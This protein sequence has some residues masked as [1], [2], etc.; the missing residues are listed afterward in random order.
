LAAN[1]QS[2]PDV[3]KRVSTLLADAQ[4]DFVMSSAYSTAWVARLRVDGAALFPDAVD[5]LLRNQWPDGSWGGRVPS[6]HDRT[7]CTLA[8][9]VALAQC[10]LPSAEKAIAAGCEYLRLHGGDW[11]GGEAKT[12]GFDLI[13]PVLAGEG[14]ASGLPLPPAAFAGLSEIRD[15]KLSMF[16]GDLILN[17]PTTLLYSLEAVLPVLGDAAGLGR[18]QLAD[19]SMAGSPSATAGH[20]S[21]TGDQASVDYLR[22]VRNPD[23]GFPEFHPLD[24]F[25]QAW[26]LHNLQRA[27]LL[28]AEHAE[29]GLKWLHD[30]LRAGETVGFSTSF[31]LPDP[32][33]TA[34]C[35]TVLLGAGHDVTEWLG[36]LLEFEG[37]SSF[38]TYPYER[39]ASVTPNARVLQALNNR[40][41]LFG[42]QVTK[43]VDY[44][45]GQRRDGAWW[46]DKWHLSPYY[47]TANTIFGLSG[48]EE[49]LAWA[50]TGRWL[51]D[52]QH[53]N[54]SWGLAGGNPEET[55]YAVLALDALPADVGVPARVWRTAEAYLREH[56]DD[57][58]FPELWIGKGLY[59]PV[60]VV[61]SA[62]LAGYVRAAQLTA[63]SGRR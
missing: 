4:S 51:V 46:R 41:D 20:W 37:E 1:Q 43:V 57:P 19:G 48:A 25:S 12:L 40:R 5:W 13:V 44:L 23:G 7:V 33:S 8:A 38:L 39:H 11:R 6:P 27:R 10:G 58:G 3:G 30:L 35:L 49:G 32:D 22:S 9:V 2:S 54:G 47:A 15:D 28:D 36:L 45:I 55:A 17:R 63:S 50:S 59:T 42:P 61:R 14:R 18:F 31:P 21:A 26:T 29:P 62:V 24:V 53:D 56:L 34:M 60:N 16:P 52:T